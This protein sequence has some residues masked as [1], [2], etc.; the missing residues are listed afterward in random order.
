MPGGGLVKLME[1]CGELIEVAAKRL[2]VLPSV[3]HYDGFNL[4]DRLVEEMSDVLAAM[5]FV[6]KELRLRE[7]EI[8]AKAEMKLALYEKWDKE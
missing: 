1:E 8:Y 3:V 6:T 2:S 5:A 4:D 7:Q